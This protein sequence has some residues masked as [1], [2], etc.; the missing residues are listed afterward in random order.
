[1]FVERT[2]QVISDARVVMTDDRARIEHLLDEIDI[3]AGWVAPDLVLNAPHLAWYQQWAAGADWVLEYPEV[4]ERDFVLT[5]ASGIHAAPISEHIF[6]FLLTFARGL[7][8]AWTAQVANTWRGPVHE[9]LFELK[10]KTLLV[11]G[12]GA[13]GGRTAELAQAFGMR[14]LGVRRHPE[15]GAPGIDEMFGHKQLLT[16]V[17]WADFVVMT[18]PLTS[19]TRHMIGGEVLEAMKPSAYFVNIGRGGTVDEAAL[20]EALQN[21]DIAGA[22]LDVFEEE[23]LSEDSPLWTLENVLITAHYAGSTPQYA[24][25]FM[26]IFLDNLQRHKSGAPLL[27]EVDKALGY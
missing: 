15:R 27:N 13:I 25:R 21:G 11:I 1:M 4:A 8:R 7:H 18:A 14:V 23:P 24:E 22:G 5:T 9:R 12:V 3:M 26:D 17:P 20:V 16:V 2:Q 19:E 6:A 10:N